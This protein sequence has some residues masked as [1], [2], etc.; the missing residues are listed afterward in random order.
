MT[1]GGRAS[2]WMTTVQALARGGVPFTY[3]SSSGL[4]RKLARITR[5]GHRNIGVRCHAMCGVTMSG[6]AEVEL[7]MNCLCVHCSSL[8]RWLSIEPI[9]NGSTK[10]R[11]L[12]SFQKHIV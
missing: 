4:N 5:N 9:Y 12:L 1:S 11:R 7:S 10:R 6:N 8:K 2:D 3:P